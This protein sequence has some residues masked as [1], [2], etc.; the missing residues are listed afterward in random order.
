MSQDHLDTLAFSHEMYDHASRAMAFQAPPFSPRQRGDKGGAEGWQR[1]LRAK[2]VELLGDFPDE[3][4][5]LLPRVTET[6]EFPTYTRETVLFQKPSK[7]D[8]FRLS[9]AA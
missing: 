3:K 4:R 8:R 7:Y 1:N 6:K 2:L 9:A 5:E